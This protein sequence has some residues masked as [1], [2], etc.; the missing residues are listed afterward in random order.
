MP[1]VAAA[2]ETTIEDD[3][4]QED[5]V[6][7][8]H[9]GTTPTNH[10]GNASNNSITIAEGHSV[11]QVYGGQSTDGQNAD[12]N[13]VTL[14]GSAPDDALGIAAGGKTNDNG[15][16]NH[17]RV[18]IKSTGNVGEY[19]YGGWTEKG[20]AKHN[21]VEIE[22]TETL[23]G[24]VSHEAYG[25]YSDNGDV[26]EN[27]VIING[28][29][30]G[31]VTAGYSATSKAIN[32]TAVLNS[33]GNVA[34]IAG[35]G[36]TSGKVELN[37]TIIKGGSSII[38]SGGYNINGY[39]KKNKITINGGEV[40]MGFG[41]F[42]EPTGSST[43]EAYDNTVYVYGGTI[44]DLAG[45]QTENGNTYNNTVNV[46][47]GTIG[48]T[49]GPATVAGGIATGGGNA[50]GN[51]V[52]LYTLNDNIIGNIYGGLAIAGT[53]ENNT[54]N[55]LGTANLP[56]AILEG[57]TIQTINVL[58]KDNHVQDITGNVKNM[59]FFLPVGTIANDTMLTIDSAAGTTN[60]IGT[61]YYVS[62]RSG[63]SLDVGDKVT[64][65][66]NGSETTLSQYLNTDSD[67]AVASKVTVTVPTSITKD[68]RYTF[69]IEKDVIDTNGNPHSIIATVTA[70]TA[71]SGG[72]GGTTVIP[73]P[74]TATPTTPTTP[75]TPATPATPATTPTTP[76]VTPPTT[77]EPVTPAP[78]SEPTS[79][80]QRT[81]S[82]TETRASM[83]TLL[84]GGSDFLIDKG[85][86]EAESV[87]IDPEISVVY[88]RLVPFAVLGGGSLDIDS[89]AQVDL[90][91]FYANLGLTKEI[92]NRQ[93]SL[94]LGPIFEY[95]RGNYD[96]YMDNGVHGWGTGHY[97]G[98]GFF[99]RQRNHDGLYYE[100]DV[101][102][103]R[104]TADYKGV[105][106]DGLYADYTTSGTYIAAHL[107]IGK[108][109]PL[110]KKDTLDTYLKYFF[111]HTN[112]DDV[113]I[114]SNL[115]DET[116]HF[117]SVNSHRLRIGARYY[118]TLNERSKLYAG[119]AYQY[120]FNGE[121]R[122][123]HN[124]LYTPAPS[125]KGGSGMAELGWQAK[126][127]KDSPMTVD[128]GVTGWAGKQQG[129]MGRLK[130][131]WSF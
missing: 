122:G 114:H 29:V 38:A 14:A 48:N 73:T 30:N 111:S 39:A 63:L 89:G 106:A 19:V 4:Y 20:P 70:K 100:G 91:T 26:E 102:I 80:P 40:G 95:G 57:D 16:A 71:S 97:T 24:I 81:R 10:D 127:S 68:T 35:G 43:G 60:L 18:T 120:E 51:T 93:G 83:T 58:S 123:S 116:F 124:G 104:V 6:Y 11:K 12:Y 98:A 82:L 107:G 130:V 37:E 103:G 65:I 101:R 7:G 62:A 92:K 129:V 32:N 94:Y 46:S 9:T 2:Q 31:K 27:R 85:M 112:S 115:D 72:G 22:G 3:A 74:T 99:A 119:L 110:N 64:L 79:L 117:D 55:F 41:G 8:N 47:G 118:H 1:A 76:T 113:N 75:T 126:P 105:L 45:G 53:S 84:N 54:L 15:S 13:T 125:L 36:S 69:S 50:T 67:L 42:I 96:S 78:S 56:N 88:G 21:I 108:I 25:G 33:N 61:K 59:N 131:S 17:N 86:D 90:K 23:Q 66:K 49:L 128:L 5:V 109:F 28:I 52:N 34:N 87:A 44:G 121:A 77:P